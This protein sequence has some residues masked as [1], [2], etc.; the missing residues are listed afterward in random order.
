MMSGKMMWGEMMRCEMI[1]DWIDSWWKVRGE[2]FQV[3]LI[4]GGRI[5]CEMTRSKMIQSEMMLGWNDSGLKWFMV[6]D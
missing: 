5:W 6:N 3:E 4:W 1:L 2:W